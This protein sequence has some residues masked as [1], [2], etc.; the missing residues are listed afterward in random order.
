[1]SGVVEKKSFLAW[2]SGRIDKNQVGEVQP[3]ALVIGEDAGVRRAVALVAGVHMPGPDGAEIQI[4]AGRAG[5]A[6]KRKRNRTVL[7]FHGVGRGHHLAGHL[8]VLVAHRQGAHGN[9]VLER[10]AVELDLLLHVGIGGERW[11]R[12]LLGG[13][14]FSAAL[15]TG[16][17]GLVSLRPGGSRGES[18]TAQDKGNSETEPDIL[19]TG[20]SHAN[21]IHA[22]VG[23]K[24]IGTLL[25]PH[26]SN[27]LPSNSA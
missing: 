23:G 13:R 12:G 24:A 7:A 9:G 18:K 14:F 16:S 27:D 21:T 22:I 3:R 4:D 2:S 8:A 10:L 17:G 11:E 6:V 5:P 15:L 19:R 20:N 1:M 26:A 25:E